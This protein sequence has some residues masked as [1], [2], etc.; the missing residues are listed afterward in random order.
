MVETVHSSQYFSHTSSR[1]MTAGAGVL[2]L[3]W[4]ITGLMALITAG[5]LCVFKKV[6]HKLCSCVHERTADEQEQYMHDDTV[7]ADRPV[8]RPVVHWWNRHKDEKME[9]ASGPQMSGIYQNAV[10]E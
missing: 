7:R 8:R 3:T 4:V 6:N 9:K 10:V 2:A 5:W 1:E